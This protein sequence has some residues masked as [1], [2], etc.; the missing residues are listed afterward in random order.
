MQLG[1]RLCN[2]ALDAGAT[3]WYRCVV[4]PPFDVDGLLPAGIHWATWDEFVIRFG[5]SPRRQQIM[6]GLRAALDSLKAAGC[7]TVYLDGSFVTS[8]EVPNDFDACWEEAGVDPAVLDPVLLT[9]DPGRVTQKA[10]YMGELF[11]ASAVAGGDGFSFLEFF[12]TD[13]EAGRPKGIVAI[14]LGGLT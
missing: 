12:Q 6:A 8:K 1:Q 2:N 13:K 3:Q 9:F 10:K 7:K 5:I 11:P 4:I 14:N